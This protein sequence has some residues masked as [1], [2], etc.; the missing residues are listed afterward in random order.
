MVI[1][2]L[3]CVAVRC[4]VLQCVAVCCSIHTSSTFNM[5]ISL[6]ISQHFAQ[7]DIGDAIRTRSGHPLMTVY[8]HLK[9]ENGNK[10]G[11]NSS[12]KI[13]VCCSVLQCV[14]V[15]CS[16]CVAVCC[17]TNGVV[18]NAAFRAKLSDPLF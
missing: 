3:Q 14:A 5:V 9:K 4:S 2:L 17:N 1:S 15:C 10:N 16:V 12:K 18:K 6:F 8:Q 7:H 11:V 13:G